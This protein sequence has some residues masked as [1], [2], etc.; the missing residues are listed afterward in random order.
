MV[1]R[2][3]PPAYASLPARTEFDRDVEVLAGSEVIVHVLCDPP[4]ATG[5]ARR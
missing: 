1:P 4:T 2:I 5:A 3:T